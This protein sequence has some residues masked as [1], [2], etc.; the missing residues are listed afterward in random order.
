MVD[1]CEQEMFFIVSFS[2]SHGLQL[3]EIIGQLKIAGKR[4]FEVVLLMKFLF[5]TKW[6]ASCEVVLYIHLLKIMV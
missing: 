1:P 6:P 4:N 5:A 3:L 2:F